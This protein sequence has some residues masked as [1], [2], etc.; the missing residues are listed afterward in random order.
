MLHRR[1]SAGIAN[2]FLVAGFVLSGANCFVD[3]TQTEEEHPAQ[4]RSGVGV[5]LGGELLA[6]LAEYAIDKAWEKATSLCACIE[7]EIDCQTCCDEMAGLSGDPT[8]TG[9]IVDC[10]LNCNP[11]GSGAPECS[12]P[13]GGSTCSGSSSSSAS[14]SSGGSVGSTGAGGTGAGAGSDGSGASGSGSG[15]SGSGSGASGSGS[16][17]SGSGSGAGSGSSGGSTSG[18]VGGG[19]CYDSQG[20]APWCANLHDPISCQWYSAYGCVWLN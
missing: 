20:S 19:I 3:G 5:C 12:P 17:A 6:K 15:A 8:W 14:S 10:Y 9:P 7:E 11:G 18:G 16:G 13:D 1:W 4:Q 2:G